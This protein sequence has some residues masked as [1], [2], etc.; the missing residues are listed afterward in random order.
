MATNRVAKRRVVA[1][2]IEEDSDDSD[3]PGVVLGG[4][5]GSKAHEFGKPI[6]PDVDERV[7]QNEAKREA[8]RRGEAPSVHDV[9]FSDGT[10]LGK[11]AAAPQLGASLAGTASLE[12]KG[13]AF[14]RR[15]EEEKLDLYHETY[16]AATGLLRLPE[17]IDK[18]ELER[19]GSTPFKADE[20]RSVFV[21]I[22][23]REE[24]EK[25][26]Q[27]ILLAAE[28]HE[29]GVSG[30]SRSFPSLSSNQDASF[31]SGAAVSELRQPTRREGREL[32]ELKDLLSDAA[33][34]FAVDHLTEAEVSHIRSEIVHELQA[35]RYRRQREEK[36]NAKTE[37]LAGDVALAK[38]RASKYDAEKPDSASTDTEL[39]ER[40]KQK[41]RAVFEKVLNSGRTKGGTE[42]N[43]GAV[44]QEDTASA[45]WLKKNEKKI[46]AEG[47]T[48]P[49]G[50]PSDTEAE[51]Y[52]LSGASTTVQDPYVAHEVA[53][54]ELLLHHIHRT[55]RGKGS[56]AKSDSSAS[57]LL[58]IPDE[59]LHALLY[60]EKQ[61]YAEVRAQLEAVCEAIAS[62]PAAAPAASS[63]DDGERDYGQALV[64][65][66][67]RTRNRCRNGSGVGPTSHEINA[68]SSTTFA[69]SPQTTPPTSAALAVT[70]EGD[71]DWT[72][73][74]ENHRL[75]G[76]HQHDPV[77][78]EPVEKDIRVLKIFASKIL[79]V[80]VYRAAKFNV[81]SVEES[82]GF[83][84]FQVFHTQT[85]L[86]IALKTV[87]PE[88]YGNRLQNSES[89]G[90]PFG[91][92]QVQVSACEKRFMILT[93]GGFVY[94]WNYNGL[95]MPE[96][97]VD[98]KETLKTGKN[99]A[100]SRNQAAPP[101]E[102][103]TL[104]FQTNVRS[105]LSK[106]GV[107]EDVVAQS[108]TTGSSPGGHATVRLGFSRLPA[109][110]PFL[111]VGKQHL[112][113]NAAAGTFV[114][115]SCSSETELNFF[116]GRGNST[117]GESLGSSSSE[118]FATL[119]NAVTQQDKR[120]ANAALE[121]IIRKMVLLEVSSAK[122]T[123]TSTFPTA[124]E[125]NASAAA[126]HQHGNVRRKPADP[127]ETRLFQEFKAFCV[128]L[129]TFAVTRR[130]P[131]SSPALFALKPV[132]STRG[133]AAP[134]TPAQKRQKATVRFAEKLYRQPGSALLW[135]WI[136]PLWR[137][138]LDKEQNS[139]LAH[140]KAGNGG[141]TTSKA[142]QPTCPYYSDVLE[143][144]LVAI[145]E[146]ADN[147]R[148]GRT[149]AIPPGSAEW[150]QSLLVTDADEKSRLFGG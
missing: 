71:P 98:P 51:N 112:S 113:W 136:L 125:K 13:L 69:P 49:G 60:P 57:E 46:F 9:L 115:A 36:A 32:S 66:V 42:K 48:G 41:L 35:E 95:Q 78:L 117:A 21:S 45:G 142:A 134:L 133:K 104:H 25:K 143:G 144:V 129:Q 75:V 43:Y 24:K 106:A 23:S 38:N 70:A 150:M 118:E 14:A 103:I 68:S 6:F 30:K 12:Q 29:A 137:Q 8:V 76:L 63:T 2:V 55:A 135:H 67:L 77:W 84:Y 59:Y 147:S 34:S 20:D 132:G 99:Q 97:A 108:T 22:A 58:P 92:E 82:D 19:A 109:C 119:L 64:E 5:G 87:L 61:S 37:H 15:R 128:S 121:R 40:R 89:A 74:Y 50:A 1:D 31:A 149:I 100:R 53:L 111:L 17:F 18:A 93:T 145:D 4:G 123:A 81:Y 139:D 27:Q 28:R 130:D 10:K 47:Q 16:D 105:L 140:K 11:D 80:F 101:P 62:P 72:I 94:C 86:P 88:F 3:G 122:N 116:R 54:R 90:V 39:V 73:C 110:T 107:V 138:L 7:K 26:L 146:T 56:A 141:A 127:A 33:K 44:Q 52:H 120:R 126:G 148:L 65:K 114:T 85:G 131:A 102:P 96:E 91:Q 79:T 83:I 124:A